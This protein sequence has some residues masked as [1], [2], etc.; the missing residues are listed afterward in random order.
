MISVV[1]TYRPHE[2][3]RRRRLRRCRRRRE[4]KTYQV[5]RLV[6]FPSRCC[7]DIIFALLLH[8]SDLVIAQTDEEKHILFFAAFVVDYSS[9]DPVQVVL[10]QG[11]FET[12]SWGNLLPT[13]SADR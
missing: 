6:Q 12:A 13:T 2:Q 1:I 7:Q 4:L 5:I 3:S 9:V 8:S 11:C 10:L